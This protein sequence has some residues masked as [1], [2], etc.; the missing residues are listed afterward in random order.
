MSN[1]SVIEQRAKALDEARRIR[2]LKSEEID[3]AK[4]LKANDITHKVHEA[5][6]WLD[7]LH[8]ELISVEQKVSYPTMPWP[9]TQ[10]KFKFRPGEVTLY[11]GSNGGGKSLITGQIALG[12][13]RQQQK[14]C[15]AS[16]EMKPKRTLY[17]ML[18]QFSGEN[19]ELAQ[20]DKT[21]FIGGLLKRFSTFTQNGLWLYDQQ[22]TTSSAQVIAMARFCAVELG[23]G[24]VFIDS[25]MK[26][27]AGEDDYNAQKY[28]V[29]ELTAVARDHNIHIHL[30][31][32]IRKLGSEE[33][34]PSKTDIKGTGAIADQVDNVL[35]MWRNK[36]KEH[37]IQNGQTP[38]ESKP[39]AVLMCEKQR[40]GESED[41]F[42]LWYHRESQQFLETQSNLVMDFDSRGDF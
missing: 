19:I 22:G 31:H 42:S 1:V 17:R 4:Y 26:C 6:V 29:D 23:I 14:I 41:W 32:H 33:Q 18:R 21:V 8:Q 10:D 7:E 35:L 5:S 40:N 12:L 16:F 30:V 25:L 20:Y 39:D 11:A 2:L 37:E 15:I 9:K 24:H 34:M 38:D 3:T 28:F 13:I 36:K 27:V